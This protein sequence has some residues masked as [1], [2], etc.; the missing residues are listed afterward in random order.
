MSV[1]EKQPVPKDVVPAV[2]ESPVSETATVEASTEA[3]PRTATASSNEPAV[4]AAP[5]VPPRRLR[6]RPFV[7]DDFD[8]VVVSNYDCDLDFEFFEEN[9]TV[10]TL[11]PGGFSYMWSGARATAGVRAGRG[12]KYCFELVIEKELPVVMSDTATSMQNLARCC[13]PRTRYKFE[14]AYFAVF[15]SRM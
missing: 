3:P 14:D 11:T 13:F 7:E 9:G 6:I 5:V 1:E 2:E 10:A 8:S 4:A 15:F 12:G